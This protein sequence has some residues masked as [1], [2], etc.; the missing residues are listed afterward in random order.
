MTPKLG[1]RHGEREYSCVTN[2]EFERIQTQPNEVTCILYDSFDNLVTTRIIEPVPPAQ[3]RRST[4]APPLPNSST[5]T[6]RSAGRRRRRAA[7]A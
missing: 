6:S 4:R 7:I 2:T 1:T 3:Y 5:S